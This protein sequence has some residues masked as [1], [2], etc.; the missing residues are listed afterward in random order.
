VG[1]HRTGRRVPLLPAVLQ[2]P[3]H[4]HGLPEHP[5]PQ[6]PQPVILITYET[7]EAAI[8]Q[9]LRANAVHQVSRREAGGRRA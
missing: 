9:A 8:R 7:M 3:A 1:P 4:R 5:V 6:A 2:A